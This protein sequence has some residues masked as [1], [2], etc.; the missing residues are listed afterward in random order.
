V[1]GIV[2]LIGAA[3]DDADELLCGE[4]KLKHRFLILGS[5]GEQ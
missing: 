5:F 3:T 2:D 4:K 1:S